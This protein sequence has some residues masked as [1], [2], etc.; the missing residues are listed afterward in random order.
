[1]SEAKVYK[2]TKYIKI[3]KKGFL[4]ITYDNKK[5]IFGLLK[6]MIIYDTN[7][8]WELIY[9]IVK[10]YWNISINKLCTS[11]YIYL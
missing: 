7:D 3:N 9:T 6:K 1:M 10:Y 11:Q 4:F 2:L 5:L 8:V